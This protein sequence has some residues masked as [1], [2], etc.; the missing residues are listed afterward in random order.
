MTPLSVDKFLIL[1]HQRGLLE[2]KDKVVVLTDAGRN[3]LD[4]ISEHC[5]S[6]MKDS[7][8]KD[9]DRISEELS[10]S[11]GRIVSARETFQLVMRGMLGTETRVLAF[12]LNEKE[13]NFDALTKAVGETVSLTSVTGDNKDNTGNNVTPFRKK[14]KL[15]S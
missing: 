11:M 14:P 9:F 8:G 2:I 3:E 6:I 12:L 7:F 15:D 5:L 13:T 10:M 1:A 4:A